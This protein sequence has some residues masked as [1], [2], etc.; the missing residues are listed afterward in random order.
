M[1]VTPTAQT[2]SKGLAGAL[3][4]L[5]GA[6]GAQAPGAVGAQMPSAPAMGSA[7]PTAVLQGQAA[8]TSADSKTPAN[9]GGTAAP[10]EDSGLMGA[11]KD[12]MKFFQAK[13]ASASNDARYQAALTEAGIPA[14]QTGIGK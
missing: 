5:L 10:G 6:K 4:A 7:M 8:D 3:A 12:L 2:D 13:P 14:D 11:L 9:P 1:D